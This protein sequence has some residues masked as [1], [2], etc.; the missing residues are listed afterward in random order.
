[1]HAI[2]ASGETVYVVWQDE[3]NG[4]ADI[5][6]NR[7]TNGGIAWDAYFNRGLLDDMIFAD[8]FE[9]GDTRERE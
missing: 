9:S 6:L 7:S 2:A 3:R 1:M 8:D 4:L 5:Y